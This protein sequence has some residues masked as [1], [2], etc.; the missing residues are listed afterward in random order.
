MQTAQ[1]PADAPVTPPATIAQTAPTGPHPGEAI[2]KAKCAACH[3]NPELTNAP[4]RETLAN[5]DYTVCIDPGHG[6]WDPGWERNDQDAYAPPYFIESEINLAM[7][8]MLRDELEAAQERLWER[9]AGPRWVSC[10]TRE[11][12]PDGRSV[13]L[14][15]F[16]LDDLDA[17]R[18]E[19]ASRFHAGEDRVTAPSD[20]RKEHQG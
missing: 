18:A 15:L 12:G 4:P 5:A 10:V 20:D 13:A 19:L 2:Y 3:D 14:V 16:D 1:A 6:G 17:A 7:G 8:L 9:A 11:V